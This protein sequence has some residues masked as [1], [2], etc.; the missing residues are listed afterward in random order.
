MSGIKES[1]S[2]Q[3]KASDNMNRLGKRNL[4]KKIIAKKHCVASDTV[5]TESKQNIPWKGTCLFFHS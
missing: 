2:L 1:V 3:K 5:I 4:A